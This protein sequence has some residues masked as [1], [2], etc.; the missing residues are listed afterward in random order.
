MPPFYRNDIIDFKIQLKRVI[1]KKS[2]GYT[3][4][5]PPIIQSLNQQPDQFL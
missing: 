4:I 1:P 3:T 2:I 5:N